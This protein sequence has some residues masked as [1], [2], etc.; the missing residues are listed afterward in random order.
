MAQPTT[1]TFGDFAIHVGNG[2]VPTE[3]FSFICG[4]RSK[5]LSINNNLATTSV[6]DCADE[7]APAYEEAMVDTQS[8]TVSGS[9]VFAREFQKMLLDWALDGTTKNIRV[10]PGRSSAGDVEFLAGPAVLSM[11]ISGE[12]GQRVEASM[13]FTFTQ[14]PTRDPK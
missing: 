7:N 13:T 8:V 6:P 4:L 2:A 12:R 11:E 14:K 3:I 5:G 1:S 9:G 10:Y